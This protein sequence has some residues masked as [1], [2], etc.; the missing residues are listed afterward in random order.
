MYSVATELNVTIRGYKQT[1][2]DEVW[3]LHER[4]LKKT[5]A[6][7]SGHGPWDEDLKNIPEV[8][9]KA[10][11]TFVI[12]ELEGKVIGMGALKRIDAETAELKRMRVQPEYQ[13]QG[14]GTKL[15]ELLESRAKELGYSRLILDTSLQQQAA[16]HIYTKHGYKE[17]KR[18]ELGGLDTV[19]MKKD[20]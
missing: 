15:L 16:L 19:W 18:G 1:D 17:Y 9:D 10:G 3:N 5:N 7:A 2:F 20:I 13:G 8:Y 6:F 12:A 14:L 4:A 11:G